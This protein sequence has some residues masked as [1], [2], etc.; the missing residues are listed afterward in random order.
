MGGGDT[1][2]VGGV[3]GC[4]NG[5][6]GDSPFGVGGF[7]ASITSGGAGGPPWIDSGNTGSGSLG[8]GE[9]VQQ[10]LATIWD[11]ERRRRWLLRR[12]RSG[13]DC[14]GSYLLAAE[15]VADLA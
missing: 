1:D 12:W 13:S 7:G 8:V 14:F 11:L 6:T 15:A 10:T 3:G 2:A 9:M 5:T 4:G